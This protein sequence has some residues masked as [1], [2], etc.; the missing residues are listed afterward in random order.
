M[1]SLDGLAKARQLEQLT[2]TGNE[3]LTD[4][5]AL[6]GLKL[7]QNVDFAHCKKLTDVSPLTPVKQL[8]LIQLADT[9]VSA[10]D[11]KTLQKALPKTIIVQVV[12]DSSPSY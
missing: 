5:S 6:V 7:L 11:I 1:S 2:L 9:K 3:Q 8:Q 4:I 12:E 10:A